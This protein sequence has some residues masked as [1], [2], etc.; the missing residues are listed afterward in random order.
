MDDSDSTDPNKFSNAYINDI[1]CPT[2]GKNH[3]VGHLI[4]DPQMHHTY[5]NGMYD[6]LGQFAQGNKL[7]DIKG[8]NVVYFFHPTS[9]PKD[10]AVA[11]IQIV[12]DICP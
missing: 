6:E 12:V 4:P 1:I 2:T 3:E 7:N 10:Q 11:Y 9:I 5:Y 8:T